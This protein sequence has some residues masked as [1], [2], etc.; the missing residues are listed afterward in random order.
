VTAEDAPAEPSRPPATPPS[1]A[2]TSEPTA[3]PPTTTPPAPVAKPWK[4]FT[5]YRAGDRVT[6]GGVTYAV[7][8]T[9][10]SLPAWKPPAVPELFTTL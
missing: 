9:H 8:E 1:T 4:P 7:K 3:A 5:L 6:F 10:T 2:P